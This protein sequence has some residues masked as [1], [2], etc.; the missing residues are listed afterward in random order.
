MF[1]N[2]KA[3]SSFTVDN[4]EK[5]K[6]FYQSVL[7][8]VVKDN[9]MGFIELHLEGGSTVLIYTKP[10]HQP[11]A[12]TVLNF[13]VNNVDDSVYYLTEKGVRFEQYNHHEY[14]TDEKGISRSEGHAVA[15]FKDPA[16]NILSVMTTTS[17]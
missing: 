13:A 8:L 3:F 10:D 5:A 14:K 15:W 17:A 11:A 16:G 4:I 2:S 1:E 9:P 12:F 7:G 6:E